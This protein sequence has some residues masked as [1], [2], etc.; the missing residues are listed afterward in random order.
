MVPPH[1]LNFA[2]GYICLTSKLPINLLLSPKPNLALKNTT[3]I[4][5]PVH[6]PLQFQQ[7]AS[8]RHPTK[9]NTAKALVEPGDFPAS[10]LDGLSLKPAN[11]HSTPNLGQQ[12]LPISCGLHGHRHKKKSQS[13]L[14]NRRDRPDFSFWLQTL[15]NG[16]V[17]GKF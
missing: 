17:E 4:P 5:R 10:W 15:K 13:T 14:E 6:G 9:A 11:H 12:A 8:A 16:S 7:V 3:E 2:V 1:T